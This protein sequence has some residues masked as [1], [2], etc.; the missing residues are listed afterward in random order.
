MNWLRTGAAVTSLCTIIALPAIG[1]SVRTDH[2]FALDDPENRPPATLD[3]VSWFAG[4]WS[5]EAFGG[6]FE[7]VWNPPSQGSMVGMFKLMNDEGV[8]FYELMLFVEEEGS[9]SFKVRHFNPDFTA[10]EDKEEVP[11]LR[12]IESDDKAVHFE[13][14]S[15]YRISD[16]ETHA[17]LVFHKGDDLV[18]RKL[19]YRRLTEPVAPTP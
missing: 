18:E 4:S 14:I 15:F 19:I 11:V 3:E 8:S 16:D 9:V 7:E 6:T 10:W 1:Q 12:F 17:Y 2:T 5:G 13:G